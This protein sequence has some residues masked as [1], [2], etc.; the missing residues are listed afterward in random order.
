MPW[1]FSFNWKQIPRIMPS[2][3]ITSWLILWWQNHVFP[4][5]SYCGII[6]ISLFRWK[7]SSWSFLWGCHET[8]W[9]LYMCQRVSSSVYP[10][11]VWLLFPLL[12]RQHQGDPWLV[13]MLQYCYQHVVGFNAYNW[14]ALSDSSWAL[15]HTLVYTVKGIILY[16][17]DIILGPMLISLVFVWPSSL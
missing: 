9:S 5:E 7:I 17:I 6:I 11:Y 4:W 3:L 12:G 14:Q 16:S 8:C 2:R 13:L 15:L 1:R 10:Q